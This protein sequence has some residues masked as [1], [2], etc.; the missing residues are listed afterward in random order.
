MPTGFNGNKSEEKPAQKMIDVAIVCQ[1]HTTARRQHTCKRKQS[2]VGALISKTKIIIIY[3]YYYYYY[4]PETDRVR[5]VG[6]SVTATII[7]DHKNNKSNIYYYYQKKI[8]QN[9]VLP[10]DAFLRVSPGTGVPPK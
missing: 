7:E 9:A 4:L 10:F 1:T 5:I 6:A 3:Y 2:H 8:Q